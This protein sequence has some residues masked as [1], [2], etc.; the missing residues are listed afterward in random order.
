MTETQPPTQGRDAQTYWDIRN[1]T[2][3]AMVE[4][5]LHPK[6]SGSVWSDCDVND[7]L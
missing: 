4:I 6:F 1:V 5:E 7:A 3:Q 2:M